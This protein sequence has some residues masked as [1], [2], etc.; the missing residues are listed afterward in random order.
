MTGPEP[1]TGLACS[2]MAEPGLKISPAVGLVMDTIGAAPGVPPPPPVEVGLGDG[3]GV[4]VGVV[5]VVGDG[6]DVGVV[7]GEGLGDAVL[8][9]LQAVPLS[10]KAVGAVLV[11][12]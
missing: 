3:D 10:V 11:P 5:V 6:D 7:E 8:P 12:L 4:V 2:V 1:V 9:P